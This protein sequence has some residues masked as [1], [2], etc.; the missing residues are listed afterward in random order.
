MDGKLFGK[1]IQGVKAAAGIE[2]FL[3]LAVA[4][5]HLAVVARRVGTDELVADTQVGGG[6]LKQSREIRDYPKFCVNL[7]C[8]VE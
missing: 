1:V 2:A 5:L 7:L 8:G 6:G 3:V 4:A